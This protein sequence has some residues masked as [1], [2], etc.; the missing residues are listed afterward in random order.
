MV[1]HNRN[2]ACHVAETQRTQSPRHVTYGQRTNKTSA[3]H[4]TNLG[5]DVA[6]RAAAKP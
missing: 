3:S 2:Q 1:N 5:L 4:G 6:P